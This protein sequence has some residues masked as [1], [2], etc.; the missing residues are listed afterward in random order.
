MTII[1]LY[2][3]R[4]FAMGLIHRCIRQSWKQQACTTCSVGGCSRFNGFGRACSPKSS[5]RPV[6]FVA[7]ILP[8]DFTWTLTKE[9]RFTRRKLNRFVMPR[10]TFHSRFCSLFI[11]T[12]RRCNDRETTKDRAGEEPRVSNSQQTVDL[13]WTSIRPKQETVEF[14]PLSVQKREGLKS[15]ECSLR[16]YSL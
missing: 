6:H 5:P 16:R 9:T 11:W 15:L 13:L 14:I 8:G 4:H 10:W 3:S 7:S 1:P 12:R 2:S